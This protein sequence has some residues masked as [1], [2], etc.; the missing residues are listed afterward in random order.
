MTSGKRLV[1]GTQ[2]GVLSLWAP[3]RGM[4][5]HIDRF[6]GHPSSVDTMCTL[7]QDTILTGSSDGL[8]RVVQLFPH[9]LLGVVGDHG[10]MPVEHLTR[11]NSLLASI[12]HG[13]EVKM[14][15]LAPLLEDGSDDENDKEPVP[16]VQTTD[17]SDAAHTARSTEVSDDSDADGPR[18]RKRQPTRASQLS[19]LC[20]ADF[21]D[22]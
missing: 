12:G 4:L 6:P 13:S 11:K 14:T 3:A 5:D 18:R 8:I 19:G 2:L 16:L 20:H 21:F 22:M 17:S 7:D 10:G 15:N 1:V 9:K